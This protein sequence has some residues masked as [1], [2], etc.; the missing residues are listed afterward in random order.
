ML[1]CF[2]HK[3]EF[4]HSFLNAESFFGKLCSSICTLEEYTVFFFHFYY[5]NVKWSIVNLFTGIL[6]MFVY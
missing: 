3:L 2:H 1:G 5:C 4:Q 6:F